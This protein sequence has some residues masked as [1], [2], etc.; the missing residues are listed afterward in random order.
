MKFSFAWVALAL[1]LGVFQIGCGKTCGPDNCASGC[2]DANNTCQIPAA[3][4]C[5]KGGGSC[6]TCIA[7]EV[8]STVTATCQFSGGNGSGNGSSNGTNGSGSN[9]TNT[10][11]G[12]NGT[13]TSTST[14]NTSTTGTNSTSTSNTG[15]TGTTSTNSSAT[16]GTSTTGTTST[17][18]TGTTATSTTTGT[19]AT[20]TT[21]TTTT[22]STS[23]TTGTTGTSGYPAGHP[24]WPQVTDN[25]GPSLSAMQVIT[26]T[27]SGYSHATDVTNFTDW[28]MTSS[29]WA[30]GGADYG[31]GNGTHFQSV[32]LNETAPGV[33]NGS[34]LGSTISDDQIQQYLSAKISAG[35]LP[36]PSNS[37][38][39][40]L[41]AIFYPGNI[42]INLSAGGTT[43]QSCSS[44]GGYHSNFAYNGR[45]VSYAVLP[46]CQPPPP[47]SELQYLTIA[48]AHEYMEAAT[49]PFPM[50][51]PAWELTDYTYP[52]AFIPGEVGDLCYTEIYNDPSGW[53][54]QPIWSNSAAQASYSTGQD[55]CVPDSWNGQAYVNVATNPATTQFLPSATFSLTAFSSGPATQWAV[56]VYQAGGSI[57]PTWTLT[58][59]DGQSINSGSS[60]PYVYVTNGITGTFSVQDNGAQ[61]GDYA[62]YYL[63]SYTQQ[64]ES[65]GSYAFWPV[66]VYMN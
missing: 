42:T 26:I 57:Q 27:F 20:T 13:S 54:V 28:I 56:E 11:S 22:T 3:D 2:C 58:T 7:G 50:S 66:A 62:F 29:Y 53:T 40:P 1:G 16:T 39:Q 51:S 59:S 45:D 43:E 19:N 38:T 14:N 8:C 37:L 18:T 33:L 63:I 25:G 47:E 34:Q 41:Y 61:Q 9:G 6:V 31:V 15:T 12:S 30:T 23:T 10:T 32:V 4:H 5:G 65:T 44:F 36:A 52:W 21:G 48:T 24:S 60:Q 64:G 49:D 17:S 46:L 55:P 35:V